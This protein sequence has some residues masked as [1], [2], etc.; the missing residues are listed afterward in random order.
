[1]KPL[2]RSLLCVASLSLAACVNLQA[3]SDYSASA[4]AVLADTK[5]AARWRDSERHLVAWGRPGDACPVGRP[6]R[7]PQ[8]DFDAAFEQAAQVHAVLGAYFKALGELA[9]DKLPLP[10]AATTTSLAAI[11]KA[12]VA[13]SDADAAAVS[14]LSQLLSRALDGYRQARLRD[15]M[16]QTKADVDL[17]IGLLSRLASVYAAEVQGEGVQAALFFRCSM[18]PTGDISD[19]FWGRR[20]AQRVAEQYK[21][22]LDSL[23]HYQKA[24]D[25]VRQDHA[26]IRQ[27]LSLD[28]A[29]L[30]STLKAIADTAKEL[31]AAR[32]ALGKIS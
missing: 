10:S 17:S 18:G 16:N 8:A 25:K 29:Q 12:G 2:F 1:M 4:G 21:A 23:Q 32:V 14:A 5:P 27:A 28:K 30:A 19:K 7:Q 15:L 31:D 9:S 20:E 13:V 3:I 24:L 11:K 22:E 6:G 26:A